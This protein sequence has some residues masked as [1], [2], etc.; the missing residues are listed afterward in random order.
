MTQHVVNVVCVGAALCVF[1]CTQEKLEEPTKSVE[2][3]LHSSDAS[4]TS[5]PVKIIDDEAAAR[6]I[7]PLASAQAL[8]NGLPESLYASF[9]NALQ[10]VAGI[11]VVKTDRDGTAAIN[12]LRS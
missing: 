7:V 5:V 8:T 2:I 9:F 6:A 1:G 4:A 10:P 11:A 12:R 3:T